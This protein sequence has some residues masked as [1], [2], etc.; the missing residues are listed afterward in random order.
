MKGLAFAAACVA[1]LGCVACATR[2]GEV[3]AVPA[4]AAEFARW[5]CARIDD[6]SGAVQRLAAERAWD[7]DER[8][9]N[10]V[11]ALGMGLT[12]FWPALLALRPA[13][14]QAEDL[15][16]LKGRHEALREAAARK[17]CP[18]LGADLPPE[19][20]AALPVALGDRLVY[21]ERTSRRRPAQES[22]WVVAA[23]KR[24]QVEY[25]GAGGSVFRHDH[26]GN[27]LE[28]APGTLAWPRLLRVELALGQVIAG[29]IVV[30]GDPLE[31]A[32]VR[33][34]VVAIGPQQIASRHFDVV[35]VELFGDVPL[36]AG[37]TRLDGA[38]VVDRASGVLLRLDLRSA[39]APFRLMRRLARVEP[40][41]R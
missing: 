20:A 31:R 37:Y 8:A 21:E 27:V 36:A 9:G 32:R 10:N 26:S 29:E 38:L 5:S 7:V 12:V 39:Q 13:G 22:G 17:G 3:K 14:P 41:V 28:G 2:S 34:Q 33:G 24:D 35:V 40:A 6:E 25:T 23:L 11:V 1:A 18:L 4:N 16:R 19:R 30:V 15:A